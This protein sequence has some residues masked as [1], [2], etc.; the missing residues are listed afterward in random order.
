M[1]SER[2]E[3]LV[4]ILTWNQAKKKLFLNSEPPYLYTI[5]P[6]FRPKLPKNIGLW[7]WSQNQSVSRAALK[8]R[9]KWAN[10][11]RLIIS[12][13]KSSF[14]WC[15]QAALDPIA[16]WIWSA[17]RV[18]GLLSIVSPVG[19]DCIFCIFVPCRNMYKCHFSR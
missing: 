19:Q 1:C 6:S 16:G 4:S 12:I 3:V 5:N 8:I 15:S 17:G 10:T 13:I 7:Q 2:A 14:S 18:Y 11:H 9:N